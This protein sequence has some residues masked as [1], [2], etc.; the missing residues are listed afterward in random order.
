MEDEDI[1]FR[2][3]PDDS[4]PDNEDLAAGDSVNSPRLDNVAVT[5]DEGQH[6]F[7][8]E[9]LADDN[10]DSDDGISDDMTDQS[11]EGLSY[12]EL[13]I[14]TLSSSVLIILI[15]LISVLSLLHRRHRDKCLHSL[16]HP[17]LIPGPG[18]GSGAASV[19]GGGSVHHLESQY[20][21]QVSTVSN[22][23]DTSHTDHVT[24]FNNKFR[25]FHPEMLTEAGPASEA[26]EPIFPNNNPPVCGPGYCSAGSSP[27]PP[28]GYPL[29]HLPSI[30]QHHLA[31]KLLRDVYIHYNITTNTLGLGCPSCPGVR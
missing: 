16:G 21:S 5:S 29:L 9:K 14:I 25:H 31:G 4:Q 1:I 27:P 12:R 17:D 22:T 15:I 26:P 8:S 24:D 13:L 11:D 10:S 23:P 19:S 2:D 20:D 7:Q 28:S 30:P 3:D 18:S 6:A